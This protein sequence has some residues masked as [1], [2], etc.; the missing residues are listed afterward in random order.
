MQRMTFVRYTVKSGQIAENE[1]LSR[2]VFTELRATAPASV[3]YALFRNGAEFVH[4]FVNAEADDSDALTT[5]PSVR[6]YMKDFDARCEKPVEVTRLCLDL[7]E[8]YGLAE[9]PITA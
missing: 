4:L 3:T 7:L 2:A 1:A 9:T 8:S 5:L 6:A